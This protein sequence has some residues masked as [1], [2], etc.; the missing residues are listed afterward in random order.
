MGIEIKVIIIGCMI[1]NNLNYLDLIFN[2]LL[3]FNQKRSFCRVGIDREEIGNL[4]L[5]H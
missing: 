2:S 5:F 1:A 4:L 3:P